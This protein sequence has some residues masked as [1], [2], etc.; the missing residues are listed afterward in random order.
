MEKQDQCWNRYLILKFD[1]SSIL[2]LLDAIE[3][4]APL[5]FKSMKLKNTYL[6]SLGLSTVVSTGSQP[7]P[8]PG[9]VTLSF[10]YNLD[11]TFLSNGSIIF[12]PY[13][14]Y[15]LSEPDP[16]LAC[17]CGDSICHIIPLVLIFRCFHSCFHWH[18]TSTSIRYCSLFQIF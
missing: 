3:Y 9:I 6:S 14:H 8:A 5:G 1:L 15:V 18:S 11:S 10:L 7:V 17:T 13:F 16:H 4:I 2:P 12:D